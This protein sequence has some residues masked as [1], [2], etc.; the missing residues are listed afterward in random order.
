MRR[1]TGAD[2]DQLDQLGATLRRQ[3][4]AIGTV[5]SN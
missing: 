1:R 5:V 3:I 2:P 4:E